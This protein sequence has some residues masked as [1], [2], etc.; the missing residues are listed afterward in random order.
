MDLA[1]GSV[2]EL[3]ST[4]TTDEPSNG[5]PRWSPDGGRLVFERQAI[6][7]FGGRETNLFVVN[8][9]GSELRRV[10]PNE[11]F[12]IDPDWSPDGSSIAFLSSA[13]VNGEQL[14]F[15]NDIYTVGPDGTGV[16]RLTTDGI[17]AL[18]NWTTDGRIVYARMP[19]DAE[20][21]TTSFEL[22]VMN[23]D[24]T[25]QT[26]LDANDLAALSDASCVICPYPPM[27]LDREIEF[28]YDA[29]WQPTP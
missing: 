5:A 12:A 14:P 8:A 16:R 2:V 1:T 18:P 20:G 28:L 17:S 13:P 19:M 9:D 6:F 26:Q 7:L 15:A 25:D 3:E 10:T 22:W 21:A 29:L 27:D 24:G 4:R 11:L 23:A